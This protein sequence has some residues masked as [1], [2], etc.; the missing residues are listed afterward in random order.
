M[1]ASANS[2]QQ[3]AVSEKGRGALEAVQQTTLTNVGSYQAVCQRAT[4]ESACHQA[5]LSVDK[6]ELGRTKSNCGTPKLGVGELVSSM[7]WLS[8]ADK[9]DQRGKLSE[10]HT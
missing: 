7:T 9:P 10:D 3:T 2:F 6:T 4:I 8:A 1:N 5:G